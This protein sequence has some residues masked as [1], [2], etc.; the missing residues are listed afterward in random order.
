MRLDVV[1]VTYRSAT[2][3]PV[4]LEALSND[5]HVVVV[6]NAS[7]D[8]APELAETAGAKVVR[9]ATNR[10]FAAAANQGAS[11]GSG[12]VV[13]FLN[14]DAVVGEADLSKLVTT[15]ESD[16][17]LAA[18]GPRL[19]SPDGVEQRPW[20]AFPSPSSTWLEAL[21]LHRVRRWAEADGQGFV[22][23]ACMLVRRSALDEVDGFDER[24]WL[25]GEEADLCR[26]LWGAGWTVR[27]V[28]EATALHIGGASGE[29]VSD[30]TFE[31]FQRGAEHFIAKHH[32]RWGLLSHRLGLLVGSAL[33]LPVLVLRGDR[34]AAL[35][36]KMVVRLLRQLASHPFEVARP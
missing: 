9:N 15:L 27:L 7:G 8:D 18:V 25:Y 3:L 5:A 6:E 22:V 32:G 16:E 35:R 17:E 36:R 30:V 10:G 24:F 19:V 20:W 31:H 26:R 4:C 34:R 1:I 2:Y 11:M 21:G 12:E 13:L 28:S 14:P 23:G 29:T 33:R